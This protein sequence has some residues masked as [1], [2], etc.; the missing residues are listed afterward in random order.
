MSSIFFLDFELG[1]NFEK[2]GKFTNSVITNISRDSHI[3]LKTCVKTD[4][5]CL[6]S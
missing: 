4:D 3:R 1:I 6:S 5:I 2:V